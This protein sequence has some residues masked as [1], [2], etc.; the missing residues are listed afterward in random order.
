MKTNFATVSGWVC[1]AIFALF[2]LPG[3]AGA[4]P[5][6]SLTD[7]GV[8]HLLTSPFHAT[9]LGLL[10]LACWLVATLLHS[11]RHVWA[12]RGAGTAMLMLALVM[13]L[14]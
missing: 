13:A 10:G 2:C 6:H 9:V 4:H 11:K 8:S 5:G 14:R 7:A 1:L 12:M 3:S